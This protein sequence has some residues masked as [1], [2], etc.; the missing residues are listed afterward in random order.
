MGGVTAFTA[1]LDNLFTAPAATSGRDQA[2]ITGL[3]GQ[4]A[5]GNEPS[6]HMAYLYAYAGQAWKTQELCSQI[7]DSLYSNAPDGL[8]GNEDCGQMSAWYVLSAMGFYPVC[9]GSTQYV[10]GSP[11]F[12]KTTLQLENGKQFS[13]LA[14]GADEHKYIQSVSLNGKAYSKSFIDHYDIMAGGELRFEMGS[15]P[16]KEFGAKPEDRPSQRVTEFP[17]TVCPS[18]TA[19]SRVFEDSLVV[20][21]SSPQTNAEIRYTI[22]GTFP[23]RKALRYDGPITI[24]T[25]TKIRAMA[26]LDGKSTVVNAEYVKIEGGRSITLHSEYAN[27]YAA[28]G[29]RALIDMIKGGPEF[30]TG[31]WQ[32]YREDLD[33]TVDLGRVQGIERIALGCNQNIKSWIWFPSKVEIYSAYKEEGP[34][35][36]VTTII[37]DEPDDTYG[38]LTKEFEQSGLSLKARFIRV[39]AT[40]YGECP[41][42]HLGAGGKTW[43]FVDELTI[44]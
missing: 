10:M 34:F 19:A 37:N 29:D 20:Q 21:I 38:A 36:K 44:E 39:K 40:Q 3:I 23:S 8:S 9:P 31:D 35:K 6:H 15:Q 5:H 32:G 12:E 26:I 41:A 25:S 24:T 28:G 33:F 14:P 1:H 30:T 18:I 17:L 16:N 13:I 43:I 22:D 42:W 2:D 7:L 27:Q 4:Y 11:Q